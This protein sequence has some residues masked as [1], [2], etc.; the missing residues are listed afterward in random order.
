MGKQYDAVFMY[1][2]SEKPP[3]MPLNDYIMGLD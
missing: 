2:L 3:K 1:R